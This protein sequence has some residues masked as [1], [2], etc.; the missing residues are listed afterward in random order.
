MTYLVFQDVEGG[1]GGRC[2]AADPAKDG[3]QVELS[4]SVERVPSVD[5]H[6]SKRRE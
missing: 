5:V 2:Q 1:E 6:H 3:G 4:Y